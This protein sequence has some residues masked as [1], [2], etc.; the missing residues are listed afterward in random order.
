MVSSRDERSGPGGRDGPNQVWGLISTLVA[1]RVWGAIGYG[2]D[3]LAGT[4]V[5]LPHRR[6][7]RFVTSFYIVYARKAGD[8]SADPTR[9]RPAA[10]RPT[11]ETTRPH[12][13]R[14]HRDRRSRMTASWRVPS[15]RRSP[16]PPDGY[17]PPSI[18]E[19]FYDPIIGSGSSRSTAS[20]S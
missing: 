8:Q 20:S 9:P 5:L 6:R 2:V 4:E 7:G 17:V 12:D 13:A 11:Q 1:A 3:R 10:T 19:F 15:S 14:P 18:G 16:R